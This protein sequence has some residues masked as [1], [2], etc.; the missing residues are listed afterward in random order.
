M[1]ETILRIKLL[2]GEQLT[3]NEQQYLMEV[4][5]AVLLLGWLKGQATGW[6]AGQIS[7]AIKGDPTAKQTA[8]TVDKVETQLAPSLGE[9]ADEIG[10]GLASFVAHLIATGNPA[11]AAIQTG[12][13]LAAGY[14]KAKAAQAA[15]QAAVQAGYLDP[16]TAAQMG[17]ELAKLEP[18]ADRL[19]AAAAQSQPTVAPT[20]TT[21]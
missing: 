4:A 11:S 18:Q 5:P 20:V 21:P 16:E 17:I 6:L 15:G 14:V 9:H 7:A 2:E 3:L 13:E 12:K 8:D 10:S 1:R 19:E